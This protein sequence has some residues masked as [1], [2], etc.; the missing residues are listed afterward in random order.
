MLRPLIAVC[1]LLAVITALAGAQPDPYPKEAWSKIDPGLFGWSLEK[2][3]AARRFVE[4][5]PPSSVVVIDHGRE[6]VE[7]GQADK[8]IKISSINT[9]RIPVS[10]R[11]T[12]EPT[13]SSSKWC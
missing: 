2:L 9:S 11:M 10:S 8:K 3:A 6:V 5:L 4:T 1:L 7:W 13:V 12:G